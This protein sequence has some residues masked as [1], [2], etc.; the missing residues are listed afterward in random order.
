M[1]VYEM[2]KVLMTFFFCSVVYV[3]EPKQQLTTNWMEN[4][5]MFIFVVQ[6]LFD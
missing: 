1:S 5:W 6:K 4:Q 3:V 2:I